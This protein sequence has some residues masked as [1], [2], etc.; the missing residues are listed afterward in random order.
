M[1]LPAQQSGGGFM[2]SRT[3]FPSQGVGRPTFGHGVLTASQ[4]IEWLTPGLYRAAAELRATS[5]ATHEAILANLLGSV[6][7]AVSGSY[8]GR[9]HNGRSMPLSLHIQ[10]AGPPLS[11][12]SAA[13]DRLNAPIVEAMHDWE[14]SW[15]FADVQ[16]STLLRKIRDGAIFARMSM[17]EGRRYLR[18][19]LST[20]FE[21]LSDLYEGNIPAVHRADDDESVPSVLRSAIFVVCVNVQSGPLRAWVDKHAQ[22]AADSGYLYRQLILETCQTATD[23][24]GA[25]QPEYELLRFDERIRELIATSLSRLSAT[26]VRELPVIEVEADAQMVLQQALTD[27]RGMASGALAPNDAEVFAVRLAGNMRRIAACLHVY[28]GYTQAISSQTMQC[29]GK[30]A[31]CFGAHWLSCVCS[32]KQLPDAMVRGQRL[33]DALYV[34]ARQAGLQ[35]LSWREA[36]ILVLAPNFGWSKAEMKSAITAICG[37]GLARVVPRIESGRRVIKLELIAGSFAHSPTPYMP[38]LGQF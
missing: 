7:F 37:Q 16:P 4:A 20:A 25:Q 11:G 15:E 21:D 14:K 10:F 34:L 6:S 19:K 1:H 8:R 24:V 9:A 26:S 35:I 18:G 33:L 30:I 3:Y 38:V 36:D 32:P 23:G 27:F 2:P 12:K 17:A 22:S 29:A 5:G 31:Q 28:E 13:H